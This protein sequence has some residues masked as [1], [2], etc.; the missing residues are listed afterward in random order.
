MSVHELTFLQWRQSRGPQK[1]FRREEGHGLLPTKTR[2]S[3]PVHHRRG[4]LILGPRRGTQGSQSCYSSSP[5]WGFVC[6][7]LC[8]TGLH[9]ACQWPQVEDGGPDWRIPHGPREVSSGGH[10]LHEAA[11]GGLAGGVLST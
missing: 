4:T 8:P 10:R 6:P 5:P 11:R 1:N 7:T 9:Q 3:L 2:G